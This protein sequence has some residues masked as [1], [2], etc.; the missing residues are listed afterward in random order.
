VVV[1]RTALTIACL[2][3]A[4][5]AA[6]CGVNLAYRPALPAPTCAV[7]GGEVDLGS[8][9]PGVHRLEVV[10]TN[11][12]GVDCRFLGRSEVCGKNS[13]YRMKS[14]MPAVVPAGASVKYEYE[15]VI[16][17]TGP[18][19]AKSMFYLFEAGNIREVPLK[20]AGVAVDLGR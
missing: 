3:A 11:P 20:V 5:F 4:A 6:I 2:I 19:D 14:L 13:C 12:S 9:N 7:A 16:K 17:G 8:T 1:R 18:F 10:I 15:F